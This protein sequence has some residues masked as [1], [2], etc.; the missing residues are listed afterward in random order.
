MQSLINGVNDIVACLVQQAFGI[1]SREDRAVK[2][3][4]VTHVS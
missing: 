3:V 2:I 4:T 1:V